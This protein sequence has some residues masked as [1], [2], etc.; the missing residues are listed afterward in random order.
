MH[1]QKLR[2]MP[3]DPEWKVEVQF[4]PAGMLQD[5]GL[6]QGPPLACELPLGRGSVFLATHSP[7]ITLEQL[8]NRSLHRQR[9]ALPMSQTPAGRWKVLQR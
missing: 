1:W 4:V 9:C 2:G 8:L 5:S 6:G 7:E 3:R